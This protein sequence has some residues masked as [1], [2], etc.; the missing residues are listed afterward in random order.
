MPN[1]IIKESICESEGLAEC[2]IFAQELYKRLITYADDNGRFNADTVIMR[3]R[4]FP[5]EYSEITEQDIMDALIELCGCRKIAF[6]RPKVFNQYG[7]TGV[8][9]SFPNWSSHQRVRESKRKCPDP[10][11]TSINDWYLRRF[12]SQDMK[13]AI[14][15]RDSLKCAICGKYLT[16]C[17]DIKRF[18]KLGQG[19]YHIDHIVPVLQG[20]RATMENLR[21]TCPECNLK[22][23]KTFTFS[24]LLKEAEKSSKNILSPQPAAT[25]GNSPP[26]S[27]SNPNPKKENIKEKEPKHRYGSY[28][29]VILSDQDLLKLKHEFSDWSERVERLSEYM[30]STGKSYKSHLAT[31]RA[32]AKRDKKPPQTASASYDLN[33]L[34]ERG[35]HVPEV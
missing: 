35:N 8:Y 28:Q 33:E 1:R 22:R 12:V 31:I 34:A 30:A 26:E 23:K 11:D 14:L 16:S 32:W 21:L 29:N 10:D 24:D 6:Y 2:S 17:R 9:G 19:L 5:R 15:E 7:K 25:C 20:G 18:L 4:L 13:R 27:E 3:A